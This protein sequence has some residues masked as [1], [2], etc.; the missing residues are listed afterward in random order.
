M[1]RSQSS[2]Y[3]TQL[4]LTVLQ[5]SVINRRTALWPSFLCFLCGQ[6]VPPELNTV[7]TV[8]TL[9]RHSGN[10]LQ[11]QWLGPCEI[12]FLSADILFLQYYN[13]KLWPLSRLTNCK[14][15]PLSLLTNYKLWPVSEWTKAEESKRLQYCT[16]KNSIYREQ[17]NKGYYTLP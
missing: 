12:Y 14:L 9:C 5:T 4:S 17:Q 2:E 13:L 10:P 11:T 15:W 7:A 6:S 3:P 8:G 16:F 1:R